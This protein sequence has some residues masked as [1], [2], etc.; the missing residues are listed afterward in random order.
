VTTKSSLF[1]GTSDG[2]LEILSV[3]PQD[4]SEM[5]ASDWARG[6]RVEPGER[7]G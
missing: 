7:C 5:G 2:T 4:K 3:I 1:I 6:V